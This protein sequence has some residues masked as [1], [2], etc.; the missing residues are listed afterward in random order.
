[1]VNGLNKMIL[2]VISCLMLSSCAKL[3]G[4]NKEAART[5]KYCVCTNDANDALSVEVKTEF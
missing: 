4:N 2:I 1:M 3:F 5:P